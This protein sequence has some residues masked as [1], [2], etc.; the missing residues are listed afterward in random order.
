[1]SP[2]FVELCHSIPDHFRHFPDRFRFDQERFNR[3]FEVAVE[4]FHVGV[5]F[6]TIRRIGQPDPIFEQLIHPSIRLIHRMLILVNDPLGITRVELLERLLS[7]LPGPTGQSLIPPGT[8][9]PPDDE[10]GLMP[11]YRHQLGRSASTIEL[12]RREIR[13]EDLE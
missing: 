2:I 9:S 13:I 11:D 3:L 4:R 12:N 1:M 8:K 5:A 7:V 10:L 6:G